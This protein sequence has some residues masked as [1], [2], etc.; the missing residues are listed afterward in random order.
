M[1]KPIAV[2][3]SGVGGLTVVQ[4]L[5]RQLPREEIIYFGDTARCPY[6]S[7]S[8]EEVKEFSYQIID[9]LQKYD[10]KMIVIACNTA[11]AVI[12]EELNAKSNIPIIGVIHPGVRS[13]I[14]AT[15]RGRV[16]VIGTQNTIQSGL[17]DYAL[18]Q[19]HPELYVKSLACPTFVPLVEEGTF[20]EQ[21]VLSIVEEALIPFQEEDIDA[22]ILGCTHY[23]LLAPFIQKVMGNNIQLISSADETAREVSTILFHKNLLSQKFGRPEHH[24]FTSGKLSV[25][26]HIA[27]SW[28]AQ[29]INVQYIPTEALE[30]SQWLDTKS[31]IV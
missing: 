22:L 19:I 16:G 14:K 23:P 10:P 11:T 26:Q 27:E 1:N 6:G 5:M 13:V 25:F 20:Q 21:D 29:P 8:K 28:L 7:R 31:T 17:Y 9:F 4:E 24:F 12:L 2:M 15:V 18:K 30:N 3:D